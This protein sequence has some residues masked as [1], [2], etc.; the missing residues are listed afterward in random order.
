MPRNDICAMNT[1]IR[2]QYPEG[3]SEM[4]HDDLHGTVWHV[5]MP[6]GQVLRW[7]REVLQERMPSERV[8]Q[9]DPHFIPIIEAWLRSRHPD[10]NNWEMN[11]NIVVY[12]LVQSGKTELILSMI[13]IAQYVHNTTCVLV[14]ANMVDSY[15]QVLGKNTDEFNN[16]LR[17]QFGDRVEPFFI[18]TDGYR[19]RG[20]TDDGLDP[21]SL[22]VVMG[23]PA[24]L[25]RVNSTIRGPFALFCDE[26][27]V[28]VKGYN[29]D[30]D[31]SKT[32]PLV[33]TLQSKA[34][35]T[36]K[37]TATPF[38]LY[39]Q[40][41]AQ[42]KTIVKT[43]PGNYR[44]VHE[45]EWVFSTDKIA[46]NARKNPREMLR[47]L[48][49]LVHKVRPRVISSNGKYISIL[50]NGPGNK[51]PQNNLAQTI[52]RHRSWRSFVMNSD[53][54]T[55]QEA[56]TTG[57]LNTN[58]E[59][60]SGLYDM[61]ES[62]NDDNIPVYVIVACRKASRAI[63]F[64]PT[65]RQHGTGGLHGMVFFPSRICHT[66][67]LIQYMRP[68]GKY[69]DNYPKIVICTT[70]FF[71]QKINAE[72]SHNLQVFA[73]ATRNVG[74]S[75][76]QIEGSLVIDTGAHD[77]HAVDDTK[78]ANRTH[79]L[80]QE[81]NTENA[82]REHLHAEG[83]TN[84]RITQM[85]ERLITIRR[86]S[87]E[88]GFHYT[89]PNRGNQERMRRNLQ[90][91]MPVNVPTENGFQVC[92]RPVRYEDHHTMSRR[93]SAQ[94]SGRTNYMSRVV[95]GSGEIDDDYVNVVIWKSDFS[96]KPQDRNHDEWRFED[97]RQGRAY[98]FQTTKNTW[99]YYTPGETRS[100][101][102]LTHV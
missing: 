85:T 98:I 47:V 30:S 23:N 34:T 42:Q 102:V 15:N 6:N 53:N 44:G 55:I 27:D 36:V 13:W 20:M 19:G 3:R 9:A 66:A 89:E 41:D 29:D 69:D 99:R 86:D 56:T 37:I 43:I 11:G 60:I 31:K 87:V 5:F 84:D 4:I 46:Q 67:G 25:R 64:R 10:I 97:F 14:L 40:V 62:I 76:E 74:T 16:M 26:A 24:G 101:G 48:D 72:I 7:T 70:E 68:F 77:R 39:N 63:S 8:L 73:E 12:G 79:M 100:V 50:V 81:F 61:F 92:W 21:T 33:K 95:A 59:T 80:K 51:V 90:Q 71:Y 38:A 83:F 1:F 32:G 2:R 28:H 45:T 57:M 75:R 49:D 35:H 93:F 54:K 22:R 94:R 96:Q 91:A 18:K 58:R 82:I 52:A 88:G 17:D 78:V 65:T